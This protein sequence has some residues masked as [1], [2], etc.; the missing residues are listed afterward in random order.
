MQKYGFVFLALVVLLCGVVNAQKIEPIG[1]PVAAP[2]EITIED[3][4]TA[5]YLV[6]NPVTGVYKF[7]QCSD[8][9]SISGTGVVKVNGCSIQL[10]DLQTG[11]RV[12]VSV[13]EC[14]QVA[15]ASVSTFP[16]VGLRNATNDLARKITLADQNMRDN[17]L[18]CVPKIKQ[19]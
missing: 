13:D 14:A 6:F 11:R 4:A 17:E 15:K 7:Y 2:H 3:D 9:F 8:G 19:Q 16:T 12:L 5:S 18:N 1:P 10:E